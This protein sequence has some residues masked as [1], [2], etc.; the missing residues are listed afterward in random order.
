MKHRFLLFVLGALFISLLFYVL[1]AG[2]F[3]NR[4]SLSSNNQGIIVTASFFPLAEFAKQVGGE[5]VTVVNLTPAG[6][7]PHDFEP[8]PQDLVKI[9]R[10]K[11]FIYNGAG[12][13]PWVEKTLPDIESSETVTVDSSQGISSLLAGT[14]EEREEESLFDPHVWLD[15]ALAGQQVDNIK[16]G[17]AQADPSNKSFYETNA[18]HYKQELADLDE[19]FREGLA[20]CKSRNMIASHNAFTYLANRYDLNIVSISGLSP[21]EEPSPKRLAEIADFARQN[22]VKYIF[23]EMLV[24]PRLSETI[25]REV[26][27]QTLVFNPLEGL[28]DEE[29]AQ[30]ENYLSV[31]RKNLSNLRTALDCK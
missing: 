21:N 5:K 6:V 27:A 14:E 9:Q 12:F 31:Q 7:E 23:F 15:P 25:A 29:I 26:G 28:T 24:Q 1:K 18:A 16:D 30:G 4:E 19:E 8:T 3:K 2:I 22:N 10:S 13:E 11:L 20:S 17:L